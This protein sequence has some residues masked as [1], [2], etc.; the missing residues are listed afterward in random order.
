[1]VKGEVEYIVQIVSSVT[2]D[3]ILYESILVELVKF[4]KQERIKVYTYILNIFPLKK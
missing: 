3:L 1:M 4:K 2:K